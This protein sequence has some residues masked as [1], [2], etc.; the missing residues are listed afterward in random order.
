MAFAP[1]VRLGARCLPQRSCGSECWACPCPPSSTPYLLTAP[2]RPAPDSQGQSREGGREKGGAE[3]E[4]EG[5][6]KG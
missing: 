5:E 4:G 1:A 2:C 6:G 3:R